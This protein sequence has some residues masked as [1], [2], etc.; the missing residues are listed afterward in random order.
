[1]AAGWVVRQRMRRFLLFPV[2][3]GAILSMCLPDDEDAGAV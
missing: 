2:P 3:R 1:M